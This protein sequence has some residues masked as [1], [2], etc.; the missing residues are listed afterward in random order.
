MDHLVG[1]DH[2]FKRSILLATSFFKNE[3]M[4]AG[5]HAGFLSSYAIRTF[6]LFI[7]NRYH[8]DIHSPLQGLYKL[9]LYLSHFDWAAHAFG[10]FGPIELAGLPKFVPVTS[11]PTAWRPVSL[12]PLVTP[13]LLQSYTYTTTPSPSDPALPSSRTFSPR[14]INVIDPANLSN[15]LG[16]SVSFTNVAMIRQAIQDGAQRLHQT[17][18]AWH[19]RPRIDPRTLPVSSVSAAAS[20]AATTDRGE[21]AGGVSSSAPSEATALTSTLSPP[22]RLYSGAA[23]RRRPRCSPG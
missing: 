2:L 6:V 10:L 7:F 17:L 15:N 9:M 19:V 18:L 8:A 20:P 3:L 21:E 22:L 23:Q 11:G 14:Y 16:R 4:A 12:T 1:R 5:S 13:H